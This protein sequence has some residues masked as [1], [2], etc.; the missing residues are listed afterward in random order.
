MVGVGVDLFDKF[1]AANVF[2]SMVIFWEKVSVY[3][4]IG[5]L[6]SFEHL[7]E[8]VEDKCVLETGPVFEGLGAFFYSGLFMGQHQVGFPDAEHLELLLC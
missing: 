8:V 4:K 2:K 1:A 5:R 3:F 7:L 6:D